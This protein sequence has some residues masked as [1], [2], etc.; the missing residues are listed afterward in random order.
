MAKKKSSKK[1]S[2]KTVAKRRGVKKCAEEEAVSNEGGEANEGSHQEA[3]TCKAKAQGTE[4]VRRQKAGTNTASSN[5][6]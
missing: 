2:T 4:T 1:T 6:G 3:G 5:G